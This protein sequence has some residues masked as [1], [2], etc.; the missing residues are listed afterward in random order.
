MLWLDKHFVSEYRD[1][2]EVMRIWKTLVILWNKYKIPS[3][4]L[5]C[6]RNTMSFN[7]KIP[8]Y[9]WPCL[10]FPT[11]T[12]LSQHWDTQA[13]FYWF[14]REYSIIFN[15]NAGQTILPWRMNFVSDQN[16]INYKYY[17]I[18]ICCCLLIKNY[19]HCCLLIQCFQL[20]LEKG[21]SW[22][23]N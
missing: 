15:S 5:Y 8:E 16:T 9:T 1:M 12:F 13:I 2:A 14:I 6:D 20:Y 22:L 23:V 11:F 21:R 3:M 19:A 18:F 4:S 7:Q 10:L 17:C